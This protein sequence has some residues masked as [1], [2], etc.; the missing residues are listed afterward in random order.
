[1]HYKL[2]HVQT[3]RILFVVDNLTVTK[4]F[5]IIVDLYTRFPLMATF[6]PDYIRIMGHA[7]RMIGT[8]LGNYI[9]ENSIMGQNNYEDN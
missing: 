1:M 4:T 7:L 3:C 9:V 8:F 5:G 2:L 6:D